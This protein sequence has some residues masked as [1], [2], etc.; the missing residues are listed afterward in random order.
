MAYTAD[1]INEET[2]L[3]MDGRVEYFQQYLDAIRTGVAS[4][5]LLDGVTVEAY[6]SKM[7]IRD[8]GSISVPE[9]RLIA[10]QPY[11]Q[12]VLKAIEKAIIAS[13]IGINPM[14]DGQVIRLPMPELT[15][16]R[17]KDIVKQLKAKAE[18]TK[19]EVRNV[20]RDSN[21][22]AKKSQKAGDLTEDDLKGIMDDVQ[23]S[24]DKA[25]EAISQKATAKEKEVMTV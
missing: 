2:D 13:D 15:E 3:K 23:K 22:F 7:K 12:T 18:D 9:P 16:E 14:S 4:P 6:G 19:V 5:T 11:D 1:N 24:T 21:D 20:R 25:I 8:L 17:R 10:I